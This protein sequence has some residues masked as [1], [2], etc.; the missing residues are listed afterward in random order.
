MLPDRAP[1][2]A[3]SVL[4]SRPLADVAG[5]KHPASLPR[6]RDDPRRGLRRP[7]ARSYVGL[8]WFGACCGRGGPGLAPGGWGVCV[9]GCAGEASRG[10]TPVLP[11]IGFFPVLITHLHVVWVRLDVLPNQEQK[12]TGRDPR[13][14]G[15]SPC[16][17]S[18]NAKA[19]RSRAGWLSTSHA[20]SAHVPHLGRH[21]LGA[22]GSSIAIVRTTDCTLE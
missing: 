14:K 16:C 22:A 6:W 20:A 11:A 15:L 21:L 5:R 7:A 8:V 2:R 13:V 19:R 1:S 9:F 18:C 10:G 4:T 3:P 17:L 12:A